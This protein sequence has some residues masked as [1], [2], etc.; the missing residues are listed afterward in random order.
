MTQHWEYISEQNKTSLETKDFPLWLV[1]HWF[2]SSIIELAS[3]WL[4]SLQPPTSLFALSTPWIGQRSSMISLGPAL[5]TVPFE[6]ICLCSETF[7]SLPSHGLHFLARGCLYSNWFSCHECS[8]LALSWLHGVPVF[9][10]PSSVSSEPCCPFW[11]PLSPS[12]PSA[13]LEGPTHLC[14]ALQLT[15]CTQVLSLLSKAHKAHWSWCPPVAMRE[16]DMTR[17][18][19]Q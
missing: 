15:P 7:N 16:I 17:W 4:V 10:N 11:W 2:K 8:P 1:L 19:G 14:G 3:L 9:G 6:H 5:L 18:G 13:L 12:W